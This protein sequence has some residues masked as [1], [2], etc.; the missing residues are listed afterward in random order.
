MSYIVVVVSFLKGKNESCQSL[1]QVGLLHDRWRHH[2]S[3]PPYFRHG[4]E[5][6]EIIL[7]HPTPVVSATTAHKTCVCGPTDLTYTEGIWWH[8]VSNPGP[9]VWNTML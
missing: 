4:T 6:E 8:R 3:P 9:L 7:Q 2:L 5:G 1:G